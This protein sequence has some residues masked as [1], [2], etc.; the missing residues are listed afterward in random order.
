MN[1]NK[2]HRAKYIGDKILTLNHKHFYR[3]LQELHLT[4]NGVTVT[5][6]FLI[7][8]SLRER[9]EATRELSVRRVAASSGKSGVV[10][11]WRDGSRSHGGEAGLL[12]DRGQVLVLVLVRP[13]C[14]QLDF[15]V[16][17]MITHRRLGRRGSLHE[18]W[19]K[20]PGQTRGPSRP[21]GSKSC[22]G[23]RAGR[24]PDDGGRCRRCRC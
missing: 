5:N 12:V 16:G 24:G 15:F 11:R 22:L 9:T 18:S 23:W 2:R 20:S 17:S 19:E 21:S 8:F 14:P 13:A 6:F 10:R 1:E 3:F 4:L 7:S